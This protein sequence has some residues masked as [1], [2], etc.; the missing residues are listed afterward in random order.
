MNNVFIIVFPVFALVLIGY[1]FGKT[2]LL[3]DGN[4]KALNDYVYY[5]ALPVLLFYETARTPLTELLHY[6]FIAAV[7]CSNIVILVISFFSGKILFNHSVK[8]SALYAFAATF[9]NVAFIGIPL[10]ITAFGREGA[11][12][13]VITTIVG[14]VFVLGVVVVFVETSQKSIN[15]FY[16][17]LYHSV[18]SLLKNPLVVA[19]ILGIFVVIINVSLPL[20]FDN[21]LSMIS[22]TAAPVALIAIGLSMIGLGVRIK[23]DEL[24]SLVVL[25]L[26]VFPLITLLIVN[27]VIV[28]EKDWAIA[29]IILTSLP[30]GTLAY[31]VSQKYELYIKESSSVFLVTTLLSIFTLP[32]LLYVY[33]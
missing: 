30:T 22:R 11:L 20:A 5:I 3:G 23:I 7:L 19:S 32:L 6:D 1:L 16:E 18:L 26:F 13:A 2:E 25:K 8:C 24:F 12:P 33:L 9:S 21:L 28:L 15:N 4:A 14:N 10:F 17:V 29:A 27:Y 31:V